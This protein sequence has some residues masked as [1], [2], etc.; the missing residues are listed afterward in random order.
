MLV[1]SATPEATMFAPSV[2]GL[3][4]NQMRKKDVHRNDVRDMCVYRQTLL[5]MDVIMY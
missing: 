4:K 1:A 3:G 2:Q 5:L